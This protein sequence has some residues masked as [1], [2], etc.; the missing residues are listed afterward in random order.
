M[1][2]GKRAIEGADPASVISQIML[3]SLPHLDASSLQVPQA[4]SGIVQ[5]CL[6]KKPEERFPTAGELIAAL[7]DLDRPNADGPPVVV[8]VEP[9]AVAAQTQ[10]VWE[11]IDESE[12]PGR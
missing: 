6:E 11:G 5:R 12:S 3:G 10:N 7:D 4:L 1:L 9:L 8:R 2:T